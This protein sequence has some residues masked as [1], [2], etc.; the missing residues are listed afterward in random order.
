[1]RNRK[2]PEKTPGEHQSFNPDEDR[3][4][5]LDKVLGRMHA[6]LGATDVVIERLEIFANA[7]GDASFRYWPPRSEEPEIGYL[8]VEELR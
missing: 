7:S 4:P 3:H 2:A 8:T 5:R 1:M 6:H